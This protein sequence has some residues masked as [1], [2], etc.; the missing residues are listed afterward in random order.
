MAA[1]RLQHVIF[2]VCSER[3]AQTVLIVWFMLVESGHMS[4]KSILFKARPQ[5]LLWALMFLKMYAST[6]V[7]ASFARCDEKTFRKWCWKVIEALSSLALDHVSQTASVI[8]YCLL[9]CA[10]CATGCVAIT[11][12]YNTHSTQATKQVNLTPYFISF[13]LWKRSSGKTDLLEML[14]MIVWY[15]LME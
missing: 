7:N 14:G 1:G 5:H 3:Q 6:S 2:V 8:Y 9:I 4:K 12:Q 13:L 11:V 15:Q 10:F